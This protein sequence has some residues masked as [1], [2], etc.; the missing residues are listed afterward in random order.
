MPTGY[1]VSWC[2][3]LRE[4]WPESRE[5]ADWVHRLGNVLDK[6]FKRLRPQAK[7]SLRQIMYTEKHPHAVEARSTDSRSV[8]SLRHR[9]GGV[10]K[11]LTL[12]TFPA[13]HWKQP[14]RS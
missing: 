11:L 1:W 2:A 10:E 7:E 9:G 6:L 13:E 3:A 14:R 4:V 5:E 12:F 8:R